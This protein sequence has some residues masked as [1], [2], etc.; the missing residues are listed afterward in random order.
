MKIIE[1]NEGQ[2]ISYSTTKTWL[3]VGDQIM[4]N[5][6]K[7]EADNDVHIDITSDMAGNLETGVGLLYVAQVDI[8]A[9]AY[10]EEEIP[11]P[12]Y[13]EET[14]NSQKTIIKRD[15]VPFSMDNVTL[16][17]FAL[18]EGLVTKWIYRKRK[19][20]IK[21]IQL[22][23]TYNHRYGFRKSQGISSSGI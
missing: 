16:T 22:Y 10:T 3:N 11:N 15:P 17:L 20:V 21:W 19:V 4:L 13:S 2:K 8:P 14:E 1:A 7:Y 6:K 9:R 5:L 12:D 23:P 18:K